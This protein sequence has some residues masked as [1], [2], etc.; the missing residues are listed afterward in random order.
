[1]KQFWKNW[2]RHPMDDRSREDAESELDG[3]R[4]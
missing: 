3:L 4:G 2:H 1:M